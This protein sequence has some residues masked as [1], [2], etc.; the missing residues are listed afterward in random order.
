MRRLRRRLLFVVGRLQ[1]LLDLALSNSVEGGEPPR[2]F[3]TEPTPVAKTPIAAIRLAEP[4]Q[5]P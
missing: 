2:G 5:R 1:L 4:P 3:R